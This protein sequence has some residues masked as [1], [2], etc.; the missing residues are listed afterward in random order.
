MDWGGNKGRM[1]GWMEI[2]EGVGGVDLGPPSFF[3]EW[4][5]ELHKVY[6]PENATDASSTFFWHRL[7][8]DVNLSL[9][10]DA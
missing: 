4:R 9:S 3:S 7:L 1:D 10:F 8:S 6:F 2:G 5:K